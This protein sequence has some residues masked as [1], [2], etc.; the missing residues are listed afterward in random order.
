MQTE[1][2]YKAQ[3]ARI[4]VAQAMRF[5]SISLTGMLGLGSADLSNLVSNGL[6][7]SAG[8]SLVGPLFEWGKNARRVDIERELAK[9]YLLDYERTVLTALLEVN[10][11]LVELSTYKEELIAN[12]MKMMAA[13]NASKLSRQRYNTT[14]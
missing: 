14:R 1:Q 12:K 3:N 13:E 8:A 10:N 6:G 11:S 5:P 7:W 4:G 9:Q 2:F